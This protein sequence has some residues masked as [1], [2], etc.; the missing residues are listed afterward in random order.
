M[1]I[2][3]LAYVAGGRLH[4][5]AGDAPLRSF[6]STFGQQVR[7]RHA[8]I[9]QRHSWK[10]EGRSARFMSGLMWGGP[11]KDASTLHIAITGLSRG[12]GEGELLYALDT[13]G[14]TAVCAIR[15]QDGVERRLL[16]G[17]PL[18]L[19]ELCARPG[20]G[21][22]ACSVHHPDGTASIAV[23]DAA[24]SDVR[25]VTEGDS[26]DRCPSWAGGEGARLV[27]QSAGVGRGAEGR[28]ARL[29]ASEVHLL[30]LDQGTLE[31]LASEPG[32]DLLTPRLDAEGTLYYIRRPHEG[33]WRASPLRVLLDLALF[34]FRL[35]YAV[36]QYLNFFSARY[37][38]KPLT[39]A[40][41]PR[42]QGVDARQMMVWSNLIAAGDAAGEE[43]ESSVP[44]SW[45]LVRV[46]SGQ[47]AETLAEGVLAFDLAPDGSV[48]YTTGA[49]IHHR[50]TDGGH[51]RLLS[52]E[53]VEALVAL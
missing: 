33:A 29:A 42:R 25:E 28:F 21:Q 48:L 27:Y 51:R 15:S 6:D 23:M 49:A 10:E 8:E 32:R 19:R 13:E 12:L 11:Q 14:R 24:A 34:P 1:S 4:V 30:D 43:P 22:I 52:G 7:D 18:M 50:G 16:H 40:G 35:L 5:K 39:T 47:K 31:A 2:P 46:R 17:S 44:R 9:Q 37:T 45:Q 36:F 3:A 26:Q 41:G 38:G 53:R 20:Q